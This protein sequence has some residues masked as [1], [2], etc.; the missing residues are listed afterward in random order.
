[1]EKPSQAQVQDS[2]GSLNPKDHLSESH[3]PSVLEQIH[4]LD[5]PEEDI[6]R[7][8]PKNDGEWC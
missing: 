3:P 8:P 2:H 5:N 1:M 4:Y 7:L 6:K